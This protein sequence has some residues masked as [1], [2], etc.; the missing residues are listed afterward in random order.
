MQNIVYQ[1]SVMLYYYFEHTSEWTE[2]IK[3]L[4]KGINGFN[5]D[6]LLEILAYISSTYV[7]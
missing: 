5:E 6:Q 7:L 4:S 1:G 3:G 2:M